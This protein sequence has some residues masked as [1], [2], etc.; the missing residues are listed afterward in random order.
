MQGKRNMAGY[1]AFITGSS[2]GIGFAIAKSL[3]QRGFSIALNGPEDNAEL[4]AALAEIGSLGANAMKIVMDV[5]DLCAHERAFEEM[6]TRLGPI[7]TLVN[8][9]GVS[10]LRRG[11]ILE[12]SE[13]SFDQCMNI[14]AKA[15][16]F[17]SQCFARRLLARSRD[18]ALFHSII[19][20]TSSN[21][22]A[23]ALPRAEYA[24]S[25][26]A[27]AMISQSFAVRLGKENIAVFDVQPGL[28]E[29][30]M[31]GPVIEEYKER[32]KDGL[33]LLPR[34][35]QPEEIG[36]IVA[37]LATGSLPYVTGQVISADGGML[38]PRF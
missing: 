38:V 6:E 21:A 11:D 5:S 7:T 28:I 32:A 18:A 14:N 25:K 34:V 26:A 33:T 1:S 8:N 16:F 23:V 30:D 4:D 29:T 10:V 13:E 37:G 24:A 2:R 35:G 19:N 27:A 15:V 17:L 22:R 31:T 36:E 9:A 3:A 20:I 12:V